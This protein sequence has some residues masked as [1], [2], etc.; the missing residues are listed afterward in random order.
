MASSGRGFLANAH[1]FSILNPVMVDN[2]V[3]TDKGSFS[4]LAEHTIQGAEYDSYERDPPPQCH[5]GT[6]LNI[7]EDI[8]TWACNMARS[9]PILWLHGPAGVG[10]SAIMQT[11]AENQSDSIEPILGATIFLSRPH[12]RDDMRLLF[13][14]LAYQLAV[15]Y[16]SYR[17]HIT[18]ALNI[19]PRIFTKSIAEQFKRFIIKPFTTHEM[20]DGLPQTVLIIID[21]LDEC[22]SEGAQREVVLLIR[23]FAARCPNTPLIWGISSRPEPHIRAAFSTLSTRDC[24]WEISVPINSDQASADVERF[25]R[26]QFQE[27]RLRYPSFFPFPSVRSSQQW[28]TEADFLVIVRAASGLFIFASVVIRFVMDESYGNPVSQL[29]K[30]LN[31]IKTMRSRGFRS[32][33]L[34]ILDNM[35]SEILSAIP[36]DVVPQTMRLLALSF[37]SLPELGYSMNFSLGVVCNWLGFGQADMYGSLQKLY[38]VL[39][40][41]SPATMKSSVRLKAFHSSFPDYVAS[42][43]S[44]PYCDIEPRKEALMGSVRVLLESF[45]PMDSTIDTSRIKLSWVYANEANVQDE[46]FV[47]SFTALAPHIIEITS[48]SDGSPGSQLQAFFENIDYGKSLPRSGYGGWWYA[49][50][51]G[52][53]RWPFLSALRSWGLAE[54]FDLRTL[55]LDRVRPD[56]KAWALRR[57]PLS[58]PSTKSA[59]RF[60]HWDSYLELPNFLSGVTSLS[61]HGDWQDQVSKHVASIRKLEIPACVYLVGRGHKSAVVMHENVDSEE[62]DR[63]VYVLPYEQ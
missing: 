5:P 33:P 42:L 26:E 24:H 9:S 52:K 39:D 19:D 30:V 63:W 13:S 62:D 3:N 7:F 31:V 57:S 28:P 12:K 45:N 40:I 34:A 59:P 15:R 1:H 2:S 10:K 14:T 41:P 44:G 38:S 58:E 25:L 47:A 17:K 20:L 55:D 43:L 51:L 46:L 11:L 21:G 32:T 54:V 22:R 56:G 61:R 29:Q 6:R 27:I 48:W 35:Y 8:L 53:G 50:H 36:L 23:Q 37:Y 16:P 18:E 4:L 60:L 49:W